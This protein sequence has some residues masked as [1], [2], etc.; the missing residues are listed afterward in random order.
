MSESLTS[1]LLRRFVD[2][3]RW[4]RGAGIAMCATAIASAVIAAFK[5]HLFAAAAMALLYGVPG[6]L[7]IVYGSRAA[8]A[9]REEPSINVELAMI[10]ARRMW[11]AFAFCAVVFA[12]TAIPFE[13][14]PAIRDALRQSRGKST[15]AEMVRIAGA[16]ERYAAANHSY[17]NVKSYADLTHVLQL[18]PS[19]DVRYSVE[20]SDGYCVRYTL[21]ADEFTISNGQFVRGRR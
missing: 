16:L 7:L 13:V 2:A 6:V 8:R 17:P 5:V 18:P 21:S 9:V 12:A 11:M 14:A 15:E 1:G 4:A 19:T 20:C 10:D 3:G